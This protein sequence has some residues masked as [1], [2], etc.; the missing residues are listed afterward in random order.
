MS[1]PPFSHRQKVPPLPQGLAWLNT[2]GP[3]ELQDLRGK[4]VLLDFWTYC[5]INCMHILPELDRLEHA[6]PRNLVVIGVHSAKFSAEQESANIAEAI[7][8]YGIE[9]PVINDANHAVWERFGVT[10]WPTVLLDRPG[11]LRG[12]G[13]QR[14]DHVRPGRPGAR[15]RLCPIIGKRDCWTRRRCSS[16]RAGPPPRRRRLRFPG[17]VLADEAG[18]RLF[19]ADS[20]HNRI[21]VDPAG[22]HAAGGDRL[23]RDGPGRRRFR[24]GPVQPAAGHGPGA[25]AVSTWPTPRTMP[26]AAQTWTRTA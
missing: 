16:T 7:R 5:C 10:A 18:G 3:L 24:H 8:R 9:H 21:V 23:G 26:S 25:A 15:G 4:F 1:E 11:R 20:N 13:H 22:R 17:K 12:L 14:R 2:A 6:Y 19:I